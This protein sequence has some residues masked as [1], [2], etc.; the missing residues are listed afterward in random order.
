MRAARLAALALAF[1]CTSNAQPYRLC[2]LNRTYLQKDP[3]T[4]HRRGFGPDAAIPVCVRV[5]GAQMRFFTPPLDGSHP[6]I[7]GVLDGSR[8]PFHQDPL[9]IDD[10]VFLGSSLLLTLKAKDCDKEP[11]PRDDNTPGNQN[12][13]AVY[14]CSAGAPNSADLVP[15]GRCTGIDPR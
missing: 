15:A 2:E 1:G 9:R 4:A 3:Q 5:Q 8:H 10:E 6:P 11:C 12:V 13:M 14:S 7:D